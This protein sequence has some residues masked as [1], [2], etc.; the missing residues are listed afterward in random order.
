MTC[1]FSSIVSSKSF[2]LALNILVL[3][4]CWANFY[5]QYKARFQFQ[6]LSLDIQF[7]QHQLLKSQT[8]K[9]NLSREWS[10]YTKIT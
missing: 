9:P 6:L 3:K 8:N 2:L 7:S 4:L 10:C 1:S 5:I